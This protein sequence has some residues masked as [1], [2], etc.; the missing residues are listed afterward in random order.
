[1][2]VWLFTPQG[3]GNMSETVFILIHLLLDIICKTFFGIFLVFFRKELEEHVYVNKLPLPGMEKYGKVVINE[4]VPLHQVNFS[5]TIQ[6]LQT[7]KAQKLINEALFEVEGFRKNSNY[8]NDI[9]ID[10]KVSPI[11]GK[12][13]PPRRSGSISYIPDSSSTYKPLE[14]QRS[15]SPPPR[16]QPNYHVNTQSPTS[17]YSIDRERSRDEANSPAED[18]RL[19]GTG[20][21]NQTN[22]GRQ[23][24]SP[25]R[26]NNSIVFGKNTIDSNTVNKY[27]PRS[28]S[29]RVNMEGSNSFKS[30]SVS[31]RKLENVNISMGES[32]ENP[33]DLI[34]SSDINNE[35]KFPP[36]NNP[37]PRRSSNSPRSRSSSPSRNRQSSSQKNYSPQ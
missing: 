11:L 12:P 13:S 28:N 34:V 30:N 1:M 4:D 20:A 3:L 24:A 2:I 15:Q 33:D 37:S 5:N 16:I 18:P 31:S 29:N 36:K 27:T 23:S 17:Q 8:K 9:Q 32:T 19:V 21:R 7:Q 25:R 10:S 35:E 6:S 14:L 26:S 22:A